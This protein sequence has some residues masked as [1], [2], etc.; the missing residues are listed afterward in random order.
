MRKTV[1][2]EILPHQISN[3]KLIRATLQSRFGFKNEE[4][5]GFRIIRKSVDARGKVIKFNLGI[6][7]FINESLPTSPAI[8]V[9]YPFVGTQAEVL[10]VGAGPAGLFAAL[11]LILLGFKPVILERGK[12]VSRRKR[13][14]AALH[15]NE[16]VNPDSNYGFGE[17]G[18]GTFS[19]GKLYT[20][21]KKRGDN[22]SVLEALY[23]HGA[24]E[25]I[26]TD[27]HPHIGTNILPR[28]I[29]NIRKTILESGGEILFDHRVT[30]FIIEFGQVQG[31]VFSDGTKRT[32]KAVILATGHSAREIYYALYN[33]GIPIEAKNF[34]VGVRVEHPQN[35]IDSIQYKLPLRGEFLPPASYSFVEQVDNRGVYSFCMCPGGMIVPAATAEN[36]MVVNGMSPSE[37]NG[38]FA[39]SGYVVEIRKEDLTK[40][41]R[42]D[43][44]AG[45]K[46]QEEIE[47]MA[48]KMASESM[49]APAQRMVDFVAGKSSASLPATSYHPGLVSS[50]VHR[51]LPPFIGKRLKQGFQITDNKAKGFLSTDALVVGVESRTSSPIRIPRD[52]VT[53]EHVTIKGLFPC[54]EGAG[55]AGGIVSSAIDGER[56]AEKVVLKLK[57]KI[58]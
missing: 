19:D 16:K 47:Q 6:E 55:Y 30:D 36:E 34:A 7:V 41:E 18:A 50:D 4:V 10:I 56:C 15:R 45:L 17:G 46:F 20:R 48:Y 33:K 1:N 9:D 14:I 52:E 27:A 53:F 39:N 29:G 35:L 40:Y 51:W 54:G 44:L 28:V 42:F 8:P 12:D 5:T 2:I 58:F 21:S 13:D 38:K 24:P 3:D 57:N 26:L 37:R 49:F 32:G 11:K 23:F 43:A 31:L 22:S 25:E